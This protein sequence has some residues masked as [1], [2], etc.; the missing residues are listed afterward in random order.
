MLLVPFLDRFLY[1]FLQ[2][3]SVTISG[4]SAD[5]IILGPRSMSQMLFRKNL[6]MNLALFMK[7]F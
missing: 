5:F 1:Y 4:L 7:R 2:I 3:L 6:V